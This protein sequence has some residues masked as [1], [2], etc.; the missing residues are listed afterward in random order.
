MNKLFQNPFARVRK[1]TAFGVVCMLLFAVVSCESAEEKSYADDEIVKKVPGD[2][3]KGSGFRDSCCLLTP[4]WFELPYDGS[5]SEVWKGVS[6]AI[7]RVVIINSSEELRKYIECADSIYPAIDFSKHS[8]LLA[9]GGTPSVVHDLRIG[10][11]QQLSENKYKLDVELSM[12]VLS[13]I[14]RWFIGLV[15]HKLGEDDAVKLNVTFPGSC[16]DTE[17]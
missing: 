1:I 6:V 4:Y 3:F 8:L 9:F 17:Y 2:F 7:S 12:T 13:A 15:T 16:I 14:D 10:S 5:I 11:F